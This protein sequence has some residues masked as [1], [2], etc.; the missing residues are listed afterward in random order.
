MSSIF[1]F[2][3]AV[4][5][6]EHDSGRPNISLRGENL[7]FSVKLVSVG[8]FTLGLLHTVLGLQHCHHALHNMLPFPGPK[9]PESK[10]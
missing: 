8:N 5:K 7:S 2:R 6:N 1:I 4:P 9:Y 10:E 3:I